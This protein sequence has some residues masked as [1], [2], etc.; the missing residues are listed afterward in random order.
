LSPKRLQP[1]CAA[2]ACVVLLSVGCGSHRTSVP[3][4][5]SGGDGPSF[6]DGEAASPLVLRTEDG[7]AGEEY[8]AITEDGA[9]CWF[10]E[11]RAVTAGRDTMRTFVGYVSSSGDVGIS[12]YEHGTGRT[13]DVVIKPGFQVDDHGSPSILVR[14][15]GKLMVFYC[16][17]RGRWMIYRTST[18]AHE[19]GKWG[20]EHAASGH[21]G[22]AAG[23][24]YPNPVS[25]G[26][27]DDKRYLFWRGSGFLPTVAF[28]ET[29]MDWS[30]GVALVQGEGDTPYMKVVSDGESTIHF[31][32]TNDHPK[33]DPE[34]S[35][36]Y[37]R[38]ESG[39]FR[40]V[41][42]S[43]IGTWD[44]LPIGFEDLDLVYDAATAGARAWI[45]DIALDSSGNPVIAYAAF[46]E[47]T[48][49]RYRYALWDGSA[50]V[51]SEIVGGGSRF[52][53]IDRRLRNFEAYYSGGL[54]LDHSD[55]S[56]VY[57]SRPVHGIFEIERWK[58]GDGGRTWVSS[59]VTKG[60]ASNNV[61]PVVPRGHTAG[62]P[63]LIWMNGPYH[64]Y[65]DYGTSLRMR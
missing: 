3:D 28:S 45:W 57:L 35:V 18:H 55:P 63:Q 47:A 53:S 33:L 24:T 44:D 49:H 32:L 21:T 40:R 10:G 9:W 56:T 22:E 7:L 16:G 36:F 5:V 54:A 20:R 41:D 46:P 27:E 51:D 25:L 11:P 60:S 42:G 30:E 17:H 31:A 15:D 61:R 52:P 4:A 34:N 29:G 48:D 64:D 65:T 43:I 37:F 59:A 2:A 12:A 58:T 1:V 39:T 38:Y 23:Y 62:G 26:G 13:E 8:P 50:W 6:T 19:I 14:P